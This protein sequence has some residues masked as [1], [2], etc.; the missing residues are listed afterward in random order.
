MSGM[1]F[2][3]LAFLAG[4]MAISGCEGGFNLSGTGDKGAAATEAPAAQT[5]VK[6]VERDVEAPEVFQVTET[7]L[8]DGRPSLGGVWVAYQDVKEPERVI[9]RNPGNGKFVIGALFRRE[10]EMPGP[11]LQ[12]SSDAASALGMLAGAPAKLNVTALRSE[13][14]PETPVPQ[15][16][17]SATPVAPSGA[18]ISATKAKPLADVTSTASAAIDAAETKETAAKSGSAKVPA[19]KP[20]K[21]V[22]AEPTAAK[23]QRQPVSKASAANP[24]PYLQIGIFSVEANAERAASMLRKKGIVP[25]IR[26]QKS[27]EKSFWR[28]IVGPANS[29][30]DRDILLEKVRSTGFKDTFFVKN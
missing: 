19:A 4:A 24:R 26:S 1:W 5:S 14:V 6:L 11:A 20:A 28:V 29:S 10:R 8:W 25:L 15:T 30:E 18:A 16:V 17:A 22:A 13:A 27:Q 3:R 2:G 7:G 23:P 21:S 9:L 12:V